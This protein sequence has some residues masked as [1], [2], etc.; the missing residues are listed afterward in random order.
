MRLI[1]NSG[2]TEPVQLRL[3]WFEGTAESLL[4]DVETGK[5]AAEEI[6]VSEICD[7]WLVSLRQREDVDLGAAGEMVRAGARLAAMKSA[8]LLATPMEVDIDDE[9]EPAQ[10]DPMPGLSEATYFLREVEACETFA[11]ASNANLV[12]RRLEPRPAS[13]LISALAE[14]RRR[15]DRTVRVSVPAFVRLE[16]AVSRLIRTLRAGARLSLQ[17][18]LHGSSRQDAVT[19]FLAVLELLRMRRVA[20]EQDD[21]FADITMEWHDGEQDDAASRAG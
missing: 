11:L 21:L 12:E 7:Q 16:V 17:R 1:E 3:T 5:R 18:L 9:A 8:H 10:S 2:P 15:H 6:S 13:L 20:V 14:L 19:H 4:R